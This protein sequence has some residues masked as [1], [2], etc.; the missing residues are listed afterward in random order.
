M[1]GE[2]SISGGSFYTSPM[3]EGSEGEAAARD[4]ARA[5]QM[6]PL[7]L[8]GPAL[9]PRRGRVPGPPSNSVQVQGEAHISSCPVR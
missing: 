7:I 2:R 1:A 3:R 6:S 5:V 4:R 8:P 9:A